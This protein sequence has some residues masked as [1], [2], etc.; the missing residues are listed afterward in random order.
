MEDA[1]NTGDEKIN[2]SRCKT[3]EERRDRYLSSHRRYGNKKYI[4][5]LCNVVIKIAGKVGHNKIQ[6]HLRQLK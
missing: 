3:D 5:E 1:N 2:R 6:K 4:C